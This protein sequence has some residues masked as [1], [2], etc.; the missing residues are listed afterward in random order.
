MV[1]VVVNEVVRLIPEARR[2]RPARVTQPTQVRVEPSAGK[3]KKLPAGLVVEFVGVGTMGLVVVKG[4]RILQTTPQLVMV[5]VLRGNIGMEVVVKLHKFRLKRCV[6]AVLVVLGL[7][8]LVTALLHRLRRLLQRLLR[9]LLQIRL[10]L[11]LLLLIHLLRRL[12]H[13]RLKILKEVL[14]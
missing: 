13:S 7:V 2:T 1:L 3:L 8:V 4:H 5:H 12:L 11:L 6:V 9:H 10:Q 14:F